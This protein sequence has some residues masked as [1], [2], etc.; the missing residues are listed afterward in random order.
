M[1]PGD[2]ARL[3]QGDAP[4]L[5]WGQEPLAHPKRR[6]LTRETQQGQSLACPPLGMKTLPT[7]LLHQRTLALFT[8]MFLPHTRHSAAS[9]PLHMLFPLPGAPST[10]KADF[11]LGLSLNITSSSSLLLPLL[12]YCLSQSLTLRARIS[13]DNYYCFACVVGFCLAPCDRPHPSSIYALLPGEE[14]S[15]L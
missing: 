11:L 4:I 7:Q 15:L 5:H 14:T 1:L 6:R 12:L 3:A 8:S 13:K 2:Q 10:H 9:G